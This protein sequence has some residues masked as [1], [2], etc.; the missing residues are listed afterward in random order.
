MNL[1]EAKLGSALAWLLFYRVNVITIALYISFCWV[2]IM[3]HVK[4]QPSK[5]P[6][7]KDPNLFF[8]LLLAGLKYACRS[9]F[10]LLGCLT[11]ILLILTL[12]RGGGYPN[13]ISILIGVKLK[14]ACRSNFSL[15]SCLE[16]I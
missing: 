1:A 14:Y 3:L 9:N 12:L 8:I 16:L 4:F 13:L 6:R 7:N 2:E 5:L 10:S 15:L 11:L